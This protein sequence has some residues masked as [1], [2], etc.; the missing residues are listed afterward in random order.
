MSEVPLYRR[1]LGPEPDTPTNSNSAFASRCISYFSDTM[2]LLISVRK[3][4][5]QQNCQFKNKVNNMLTI[6]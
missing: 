2:Y 1:T 6:L 3:S 5:S 4:T